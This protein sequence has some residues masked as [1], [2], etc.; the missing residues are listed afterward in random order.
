M[1]FVIAECGSSWR[2]GPD[3]EHLSNAF[4]MIEAVKVCGADVAK[5][6]WC[7]APE[8]MA[9]RR[10]VAENGAMYRRYLAY[11]VEWLARLKRKC[12]EAGIEF[13]C[14]VYVPEDVEVVAPL[15]QRFKISAFEGML[16]NFHAAH[17]RYAKPIIASCRPTSPVWRHGYSP[18]KK[19][20]ACISAYP[21]PLEELQLDCIRQHAVD[22]LSDHSGHVL[23]GAVAVACGAEI[24]EV[25][26]RLHDTPPDNP[27]YPHSHSPESLAQYVANI[28]TAERML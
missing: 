17:E 26:A 10:G 3:S 18:G 23:T 8:Q 11:P 20:L 6:Q 5:F 2:F 9:A 12:D 14:T 27:D 25:H 19:W 28:R 16:T 7:S 24:V 22:G 15:V 1:T 13:M 21:T 4:R